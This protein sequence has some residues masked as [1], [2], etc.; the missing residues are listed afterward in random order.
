MSLLVA[1]FYHVYI[2]LCSYPHLLFQS[3][4]NTLVDGDHDFNC[5][6]ID[7]DM[8]CRSSVK[9][10]LMCEMVFNFN[11]T[12]I[13][14]CLTHVKENNLDIVFTKSAEPVSNLSMLKC[15]IL[16]SYHFIISFSIRKYSQ[17]ISSIF[18]SS[19]FISDCS[20]AHFTCSCKLCD[21][22]QTLSP[23]CQV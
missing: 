12:Q 7:W 9:L 3:N 14:N 2:Y 23:S 16:T 11:L 4:S 13:S 21:H 10:L 18:C 6:E 5:P 22:M 17:A 8:L 19:K 1:V 20:M 15:A